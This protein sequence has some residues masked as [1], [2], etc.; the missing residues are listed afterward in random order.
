M[1]AEL[2]Y[3]GLRAFKRDETI[4]FF[5]REDSIDQMVNTLANTHFLAVLGASGSGKSSLVRTGLLDGLELGLI[6]KGG[7]DWHI[8]DFHPG[9][10]PLANLAAALLGPDRQDPDEI[11]VLRSFLK[12]GPRSLIQWF[13]AGNL[14]EGQSLL[15]FADQFEELF[16]YGNY[17]EREEAEAFVA[18]L[19]ETAS[20]RD[21]P[22]Y[23]VLTM[24]SEYLGSCSLI[25]GLA[26]RINT[27][28]YL[29][30][31]MNRD[32]C[33]EAIEG[34]ARVMGFDIDPALTNRL[35]NDL[36]S[37]AP[38]SEEE[39]VD[40]LQR[41]ARRA[42]QLPLM[43]HVLNQLF[44]E[45]KARQAAV[46]HS[47]ERLT[48]N[49]ADYEESGG[50]TGSIDR[51]GE[52]ILADLSEDQRVTAQ[53][54][55]RALVTGVSIGTAVRRPT[56]LAELVALADG[57]ENDV[58]A[59]V[60]RLRQPDCNFLRP[61]VDVPLASETVIDIGHESLIRQWTLLSDLLR[62]EAAAA[63]QWQRLRNGAR[64]HQK[65]T[66]DLLH[67]L[68]LANARA[69]WDAEQPNTA[70]AERHGGMYPEVAAFLDE[71]AARSDEIAAVAAARDNRERRRL[72]IGAAALLGLFL[73]TSVF[74]WTTVQT[75]DQLVEREGD[76]EVMN[77]RLGVTNTSLETALAESERQTENARMAALN[78]EAAE[79]EAQ[80][81][82]KRAEEQTRIARVE[83][84]RAEAATAAAVEAREFAEQ[85]EQLALQR[86]AETE[87]ANLETQAMRAERDEVVANVRDTANCDD[88]P[89]QPVCRT[90]AASFPGSIQSGEDGVSGSEESETASN[91][92]DGQIS[93]NVRG[94]TAKQL[95]DALEANRPARYLEPEFYPGAQIWEVEETDGVSAF[96]VSA[97]NKVYPLNGLS[98]AIHRHNSENPPVMQTADQAK[99]YLGFFTGYVWS[100]QG[101]FT[102]MA[103]RDQLPEEQ[104]DS[105]TEPTL[106]R[107]EESGNWRADAT[108]WYG[109][110]LFTADME[111][112]PT[113]M[114]Q[115]LDDTPIAEPGVQPQR[116]RNGKRSV[117]I[118][119]TRVTALGVPPSMAGNWRSA[120][121]AA[122]K[123]LI[124]RSDLK[125]GFADTYAA[126][127][128]TVQPIKVG[129]D[130]V[131]SAALN[132]IVEQVSPGPAADI[133][134]AALKLRDEPL[135]D[136]DF[137]RFLKDAASTALNAPTLRNTSSVVEG[138]E[139]DFIRLK[140][141]F[142]R[143]PS[144][145]TALE[146]G[147]TAFQLA[148]F[149]YFGARFDLLTSTASELN[150]LDDAQLGAI[151]AV[152]R[153]LIEATPLYATALKKFVDG[154][155]TWSTEYQQAEQVLA[156]VSDNAPPSVIEAAGLIASAFVFGDDLTQREEKTAEICG[157]TDALM[158][159]APD[160]AGT[161]WPVYYCNSE[162]S[163]NAAL[164]GEWGDVEAL[165]T[166]TVQHI[167]RALESN[168]DDQGLLL[169]LA[170]WRANQL[171]F[172][173][174]QEARARQSN[175]ILEILEK[176]LL[177][178]P[179]E[180]RLGAGRQL[181]EQLSYYRG[182]PQDHTRF[183]ARVFRI[184]APIA[185][186]M[187]RDGRTAILAAIAGS[188]A[189][190]PFVEGTEEEREIASSFLLPAV[191]LLERENALGLVTD[192][193]W[194]IPDACNVYDEV[195]RL[196][197]AK[198]EVATALAS[199]VRFEERC[200][201]V[202]KRYPSMQFIA[203]VERDSNFRMG[204]LLDAN[205]RS[206]EAIAFL[207]KASRAGFRQA[208]TLLAEMTRNGRGRPA[209]PNEADRLERLANQQSFSRRAI[210]ARP[211]G[212]Y[213]NVTL[214]F[215]TQPGVHGH[216]QLVEQT[217][218][219][220]TNAKIEIE[221]K[222]ADNLYELADLA[223]IKG[224]DF[225]KLFGAY[226][227]NRRKDEFQGFPKEESYRDSGLVVSGN[228]RIISD[229]RNIAIDGWDPVSYDTNTGKK[230]DATIFTEHDGVVWLF[231]S[232]AHRELFLADPEKYVPAAG[233]FC[234]ICSK[235][236]GEPVQGNPRIWVRRDGVTRFFSSR[237]IVQRWFREN[238]GKS[239]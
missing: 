208:T 47:D 197:E 122:R 204:R 212:Q 22:I 178:R 179:F 39:S 120:D 40:Q 210:A 87:Q 189:A 23:V 20:V 202:L 79:K 19:L 33:G 109:K 74:A 233:G 117:V 152:N 10:Q 91:N 76:L 199:K 95:A 182:S 147:E 186:T 5:G 48:L 219:Y 50:L 24:R 69:W 43:Q 193:E 172:E 154:E 35:L 27:G 25:D 149:A 221:S 57:N 177:D 181:V 97:D 113:G 198:G 176:S 127:N 156:A 140:R 194:F 138:L 26:E 145:Q 143:Q 161:L 170:N 85:Q 111:I 130:A 18:L 146:L 30:P 137:N 141:D 67:G 51:H 37:F 102:L 237:E 21:L 44:G 106:R 45:A 7:S 168:P 2:P 128:D 223:A 129:G 211:G 206:Q 75:N 42:D 80:L 77:D 169:M 155:S 144:E 98:P 239:D 125:Q 58:R 107:D 173:R 6:R 31:R 235:E 238:S 105:F 222:L 71:S 78:A 228:P 136:K 65:G 203:Q 167:E 227:A 16:R 119:G 159:R 72:Q 142:E 164:R 226:A 114:I 81:A 60:E 112:Q 124:E 49:L 191:E 59:V 148:K 4:V 8:A 96:L 68:D 90:L 153:S 11:D 224:I 236:A 36:A 70:W 29:T 184:F 218:D 121:Q 126:R 215:E 3:P 13:E 188:Q 234:E 64:R 231:S 195:T 94:G 214:G 73:T 110:S 56:S 116:F 46:G 220:K 93:E 163:E 151:S 180:F 115:M 171:R 38:W 55:M 88:N 108:I 232:Y 216:R 32:A 15:V 209:D 205:G 1:F 34:P 183:W 100:D 99:G 157:W 225:D 150:S 134:P 54:V 135:F 192:Y 62:E 190:M 185:D 92:S 158:E 207:E 17:A 103:E 82:L 165:N 133:E 166:V 61:E 28:T 89:D 12:I 14:P 174:D 229:S 118:G 201:P 83:R 101:A 230:G 41:L 217:A 139:A 9:Q 84:S 196:H 187:P 131:S 86:L 53:T 160:D 200:L 66:G 213:G 63:D 123:Q 132:A 162:R 175:E 104:R 52:A